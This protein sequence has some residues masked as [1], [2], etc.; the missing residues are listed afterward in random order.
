MRNMYETD[1]EAYD[2]AIPFTDL[3]AE[4]EECGA[5]LVTA[6]DHASGFCSDECRRSFLADAEA[7][8]VEMLK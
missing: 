5:P 2:S 1:A 8:L 6:D 4:C 3:S 7:D